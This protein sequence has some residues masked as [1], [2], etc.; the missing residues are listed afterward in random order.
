MLRWENYVATML[1]RQGR[2]L[3]LHN[4]LGRDRIGQGKEKLCRDRAFLCCDKGLPGR[5]KAG[6]GR[7]ALSPTTQLG[8]HDRHARSTGMHSRKRRERDRDILSRQRF[9]YCERLVQYQN[10]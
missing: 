10:K 7:G 6:H 4:I 5:D 1:A 8:K 3:L 9:L 2:L